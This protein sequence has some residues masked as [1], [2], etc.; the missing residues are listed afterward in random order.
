M[1]YLVKYFLEGFIIGLGKIIP[2]VSGAL[3]AM[4][5]GVYEN[6][7]ECIS[8]PKSILKN[9]KIMLPLILG[10]MISIVFFSNIIK[11]MLEH[12]YIYSMAFFIGMMSFG[13][14]PLFKKSRGLQLTKTERLGIIILFIGILTLMFIPINY[15]KVVSIG[16]FRD[17]ISLFLCGILDAIA[18]I[19]PGI[20]GT[21]LLMLV[22]YYEIIISSLSNV[23]LPVLLPFFI[24][25]LIGIISLAKFINYAFKKHNSFMNVAIM[26]FSLL[27]IIILT[28]ELIN[29]LSIKDA[30]HT[31]LFFALGFYISYFVE[32]KLN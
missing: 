4:M 10:I 31:I 20:S 21:S 2:G 17:V 16:I 27:S 30:A 5:F 19:I 14:I 11:L 28:I 23:Y 9:N 7:I 12:Y 18:T 29:K 15:N 32:R 8:N 25:L 3:F 26:H 13:L 1:I 24:G 22:G 6:I